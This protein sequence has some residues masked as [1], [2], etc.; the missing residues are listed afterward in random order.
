MRDP[1]QYVRMDG[2][3]HGIS[4][5][6]SLAGPD[7]I[8]I[9][10]AFNIPNFNPQVPCGTRLMYGEWQLEKIRISIHRSLAGPDI[11]IGTT[12]CAMIISIHRSLAGPDCMA[13]VETNDR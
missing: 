13:N 6:R 12:S 2:I 3:N 10:P 11:S 7:N 9:R 5:H 4:I 8:G 1:T